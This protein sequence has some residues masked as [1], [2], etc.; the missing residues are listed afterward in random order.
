VANVVSM[1]RKRAH[2]TVELGELFDND[3]VEIDYLPAAYSY[4]EHNKAI[5]AFDD[6]PDAPNP[7]D[8]QIV[9]VIE[10]W[11]LTHRPMDP[12]TG[13][14]YVANGDGSPVVDE[15]GRRLTVEDES[16]FQNGW[17]FPRDEH[18]HDVFET[19]PLTLPCMH[20]V[21]SAVAAAVFTRIQEALVPNS[22]NDSRSNRASRR[23]GR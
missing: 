2:L 23:A 3:V 14:F 15:R 4:A 22:K 13:R 11:D 1:S 12:E 20:R 6:D 9:R 17:H 8:E 10:R 5:R 7:L 18:G 21:P 19:I 16:E